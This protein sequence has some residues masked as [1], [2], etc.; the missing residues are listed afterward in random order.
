MS[1]F[2]HSHD[3]PRPLTTRSS[4]ENTPMILSSPAS[5]ALAP[6]ASS[7]PH[8]DVMSTYPRAASSAVGALSTSPT[9]A[10]SP[11]F[12][13][14]R[15]WRRPPPAIRPLV[16]SQASTP[17]GSD[18]GS[19]LGLQPSSASVKALRERFSASPSLMA[20]TSTA[21]K[22]SDASSKALPVSDRAERFTSIAALSRDQETYMERTLSGGSKPLNDLQTLQIPRSRSPGVIEERINAKKPAPPPPLSRS[23]SPGL[24]RP[25]DANNPVISAQM[26]PSA[27]Q[28]GRVSLTELH[29]GED[30]LSAP[31]LP[32]RTP[33]SAEANQASPPPSNSSPKNKPL[34]SFVTPMARS[35]STEFASGPPRLPERPRARTIGKADESRHANAAPRL[36]SR[37]GMAAMPGTDCT[38][39]PPPSHHSSSAM[40]PQRSRELSN[41]NH[42]LPPMRSTT[43]GVVSSPPQR[44]DSKTGGLTSDDEDEGEEV[45]LAGMTAATKRMYEDFPDS[46]HVRRRP[47]EFVPVVRISSIQHVNSFAV[48]GRYVCTGAHHVR[49][50][51]TQMSDRPIFTVDMQDVGLEFRIKEPRVTAMC[52]RPVADP[53][54]EGRYLWCGTKDGHLWEL[55]IR[56]GTVTDRRAFVHAAVVTNIFRHQQQVLTLDESGKL[57]VFEV[58]RTVGSATPKDAR[59]ISNLIRSFRITEKFTFAKM[60]CGKLWI[61]SAPSNRSTTNT[62]SRGPT[63]R[64]YEPCVGDPMPVGR[65]IS[66]SEWTGAVTSATIMPLQ[67]DIVY[68]GH[69]GG[70]VSTWSVRDLTCLQVLKIS[71]TDIL[72]LE[73]VGER[74]W[75]GNRKGQI[76]VYDPSEKPWRTTKVWTA[77][78]DLPIHSLLLDPWSIEHAGRFVLWS[79]A[80]DTIR[81]WDG[82]LSVD[83][84]GVCFQRP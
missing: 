23:V 60:I 82:L 11:A 55:D 75:A 5:F 66:T 61:S 20:E 25:N 22:K 72:A 64:V 48:F 4:P 68:I 54:D 35:P 47:P 2:L 6:G 28:A 78:P 3:S 80:R 8:P 67:A 18:D 71:S 21:P 40:S 59:T 29:H 26:R 19:D 34:A 39:P 79:A 1:N 14:A 42:Q 33:A 36:P 81:A 13:S 58:V 70:F 16:H 84:I 12:L 63:I 83:W 52:F 51:D 62:S 27:D 7:V 69:E 74:L 50:Y 31:P 24:S 77:H 44:E 17:T 37:T 30:K 9:L 65:S 38:L 53:A 46:T 15:P 32:P 43:S 76:H 10:A 57:H 73:G 56:T 41:D 49:V 45:P